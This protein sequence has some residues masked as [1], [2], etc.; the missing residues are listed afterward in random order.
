M[1]RLLEEVWDED[2]L[3]GEIDRVEAMLAGDLTDRQRQA[4][5]TMERVRAFVRTLLGRLA[6]RGRQ[7]CDSTPN[8]SSSRRGEWF[9]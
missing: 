1:E 5:Q 7:G 3:I 6:N 2:E 8:A 9:V 4:P